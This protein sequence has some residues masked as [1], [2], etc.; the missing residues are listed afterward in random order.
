VE[1]LRVIAG[2]AKGRRIVSQKRLGARPTTQ[3]VRSSLFAI[4]EAT[5]LEGKNV[6]D[7]YAGIGTL[8]IE[9]LS[10]GALWADFIEGSPKRCALL[11]QSLTEMGFSSRSKVHC[12][13]VERA[14][15]SLGKSYDLVL[16][17]PPY[18]LG[19]IHHIMEK[20]GALAKDGA[21]VATG[22]SKHHQLEP[23]YAGLELIRERRYGDTVCS[24]YREGRESW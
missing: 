20:V 16:M 23:S 5:G 8:G 19:P 4:L 18:T 15:T 21:L 22:H 1:H 17:D 2:E 12:M 3:R 6:V 14:I 13:K 11:R 7:L 24:I 9:A 10:R